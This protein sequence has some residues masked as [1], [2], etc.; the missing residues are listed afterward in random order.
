MTD[1]DM[2]E[3]AFGDDYDGVYVDSFEEEDDPEEAYEDDPDMK[4]ILEA[5]AELA[6]LDKLDMARR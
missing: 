4:E 3:E 2:V 6:E 5:D 1:S